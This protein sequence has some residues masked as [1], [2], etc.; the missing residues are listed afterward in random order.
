MS[1]GMTKPLGVISDSCHSDFCSCFI[2]RDSPDGKAIRA[3]VQ[4]PKQKLEIKL[5][6]VVYVMP[7][8]FLPPADQ[9]LLVVQ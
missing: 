9:G 3:R 4:Q 7:M 6:N 2:P 8:G 5:E 1:D